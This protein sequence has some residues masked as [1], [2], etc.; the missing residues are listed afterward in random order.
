MLLIAHSALA[1][2]P[3]NT[4]ISAWLAKPEPRTSGCEVVAACMVAKRMLRTVQQGARPFFATMALEDS[5]RARMGA[6]RYL[7]SGDPGITALCDAALA[8]VRL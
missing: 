7:K 4:Q 5:H 1:N 8:A 6:M 3:K 2:S